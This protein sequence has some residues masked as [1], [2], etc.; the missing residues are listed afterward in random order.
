MVNGDSPVIN[1]S[2][3]LA[4]ASITNIEKIDLSQLW[5]SYIRDLLIDSS[6]YTNRWTSAR[7]LQL[8]VSNV[9]AIT[10]EDNILFVDG[11]AGD[12]VFLPASE[13][14]TEE[15]SDQPGYDKFVH[16]G[17]E[18]IIYIEGDMSSPL[19]SLDNDDLVNNSIRMFPNPASDFV[20]LRFT[21]LQNEKMTVSLYDISG[22][23]VMKEQKSDSQSELRMN[24]SSLSSGLYL[25]KIYN[26]TGG[27][28]TK[29][30]MIK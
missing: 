29:K 27:E 14:W 21:D 30:L 6:D 10:D 26:E 15:I 23:L 17:G 25:M 5:T 18:E 20:T 11:D 2:E 8:I 1:V 12:Y 24:I 9:I 3:L 22:R 7:E 19:L 4:G 13:G 16:P 28:R